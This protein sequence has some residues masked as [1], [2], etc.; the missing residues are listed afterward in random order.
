[1]HV[2]LPE[3]HGIILLSV[4]VYA[5]VCGAWIIIKC[6]G[7]CMCVREKGMKHC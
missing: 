3:G 4:R 2:C 1:M 5:S 6:E 7:T